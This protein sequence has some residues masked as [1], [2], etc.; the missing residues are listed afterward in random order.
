MDIRTALEQLRALQQRQYAYYHAMTIL[1]LDGATAAPRD[2]AR[3]RGVAMGILAGEKHKL[4][5]GE[6]VGKLLS[7]LKERKEE[8]DFLTRR[9]VEELDQIGR[10]HV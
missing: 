4:L 10:A 7:F 9:Q 8:L 3:G 5:S 2:T 1:E 6:E